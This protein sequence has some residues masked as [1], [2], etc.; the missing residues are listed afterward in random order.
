[1]AKF[2]QYDVFRLSKDLNPVMKKGMIGAILEVYDDT[3]FEV[4]FSKPDGTDY[5]FEGNFTFSIDE[6]YMEKIL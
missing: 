5:E 4:E 2:E 6:S 3:H 1:M